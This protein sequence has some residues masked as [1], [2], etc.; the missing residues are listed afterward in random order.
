M[1]PRGLREGDTGRMSYRFDDVEIDP[2]AFRVTKAGVPVRLEPKAVE[3]LL[4]LAGRP[5]RLVTKAE[6]QAAV[7]KDTAVTEN[8]LTRLVAQIRRG[9]GDDAREARYIETVP[10]RGY[11]FVAP[12][13]GPG[14]GRGAP[15]E[16]GR[17]AAPATP[18]DASGAEA[19]TDRPW[20]PGLRAAAVLCALLAAVLL[21]VAALRWSRRPA[22][23]VV[24]P[25]GPGALVEQQVSTS[26]S[27]NVFPGFSPDGASIAFASLRGG[28]MEIVRRALAPGAREIAITGDGMQNV[29]PA[30][31]PDGRLIAYHSVGRGGL[32]LVPALGGV[33]RQLTRF[34]S[35]PAW[36]PDGAEIAFQGQSWV[37]AAEGG[38][39]AGEGSTMWLVS[40]AGGEPRRLTTIAAV[41]PGG[42]G[43]PAWSPDG[44]LIAFL[45]GARVMV[46]GRDGSGL[47]TTGTRLWTTGV[48]W[49]RSGRSQ[50]W[51]GSL[52]GN[53]VAWRV[54][55]SPG[56]GAVAGPEQVLASGGEGAS[57]WA[58]PAVSP[59]GRS[60][61][62]V[63]FRTRYEIL[64]QEVT[65]DGRPVGT[66][67]A[68]VSGVGGRKVPLG[69]SPDGRRLS[70]GTVRP[71]VGRS[72]W[73]ADLETGEA[74]LVLEQP[75]IGWVRGFFP[76]G[77]RLGFLQSEG[78]TP[79]LWTVD[80]DTGETRSLAPLGE[81]LDWPAL[82]SPD[83]RRVAAHRA[84]TGGLDVWVVDLDGGTARQVTHDAEGVGWPSWSPDGTRLA[85]EMMR[86]GD[87]HVG[88][89]PAG[90]GPVRELVVAPGQSWPQSF[91]P[92]GRRIAYAGQR[93]GVW[94]VYSV[95]V[96][97]GEERPLTSYTTPALYVRYP[98]WSSRGR[99]LFEYAESASTVWAS[100]LPPAP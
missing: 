80:A 57:A 70:F 52:G 5:G 65:R 13:L 15:V 84:K 41:G 31:S 99:V 16:N 1:D 32:W 68:A 92:D 25:S 63:R 55:V 79:A 26:A 53:W 60:I 93:G 85:V 76:D 10:T 11:R 61:A 62:Y 83:G 35:F 81:L 89:L 82:V 23:T 36:S 3:L 96:D 49:D 27:L 94:N 47:L 43:A 9:L 74:K 73:V 17:A 87:T 12:V 28:S 22:V 75:R 86:G 97:G 48:A 59:D 42:Q 71:G 4:L 39:A 90:G 69:L 46:V 30:F 78:R 58:H 45:A 72:L 56:T 6:I 20:A 37:G 8:A 19:A 21:G 66:P 34:G 33:P 100:T 7:W 2:E 18:A 40:A 98:F 95:P 29:Q 54:P 38:Y 14:N 24:A 44:R 67:K 88:L 51:T 77:R 64:A 91:S 50:I